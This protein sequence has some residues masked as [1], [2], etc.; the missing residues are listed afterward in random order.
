M[1]EQKPVRKIVLRIA[2]KKGTCQFN[3]HVGQEFELGLGTPAGLCPG[4]YNS[5]H[6]TIFAMQ[7]GARFPWANADGSVHIACPD[8]E[9]QVVME[10]KPGE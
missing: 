10:I 5:A 9:N 1:S 6:P 4:A 7:F 3:H 8:P 2:S